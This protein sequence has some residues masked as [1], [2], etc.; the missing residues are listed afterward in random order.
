[1]PQ[2]TC[3]YPCEDN[4]GAFIL[5]LCLPSSFWFDRAVFVVAR[6]S[7]FALRPVGSVSKFSSIFLFL[8]LIFPLTSQFP[9]SLPLFRISPF[10]VSLQ[11]HRFLHFWIC[12]EE[13][14]F[15]RLSW[16]LSMSGHGTPSRKLRI[17]FSKIPFVLYTPETFYYLLT[18]GQT[19]FPSTI[20]NT[21]PLFWLFAP[22]VL[23]YHESSSFQEACPTALTR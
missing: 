21:D 12:F 22:F 8:T 17:Y 23:D 6:F 9:Y 14:R 2:L 19:I 13:I 10:Q 3:F 4:P 18:E 16:K 20:C 15:I 7:S 11:L 1:V 5:Y